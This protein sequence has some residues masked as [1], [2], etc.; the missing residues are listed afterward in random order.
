MCAALL[1]LI[2]R[3][4]THGIRPTRGDFI[5]PALE[6]SYRGL[7]DS[8]EELNIEV[9]F[10]LCPSPLQ[11]PVVYALTRDDHTGLSSFFCA[12]AGAHPNLRIAARRALIEACQSRCAFISALRDDVSEKIEQFGK[13]SYMSRREELSPWFPTGVSPLSP[14]IASPRF[15]SFG[16]LLQHLVAAVAKIFPN[17]VLAM[18]PVSHFNDV[19]A[20][21]VYSP[22]LFPVRRLGRKDS[23]A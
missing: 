6:E 19:F 22:D 13:V 23:N 15:H 18:C 5:L 1:E 16:E 12:G 10:L 2:E 7:L 4:S 11:I 20:Y 8:F 21:R 14:R 17:T 9:S 3:R